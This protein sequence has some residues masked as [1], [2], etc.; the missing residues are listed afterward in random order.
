MSSE[1][2]NTGYQTDAQR[3]TS[4]SLP[5]L[6]GDGLVKLSEAADAGIQSVSG[7][8][9]FALPEAYDTKSLTDEGSLQDSDEESFV[10]LDPAAHLYDDIQV[11]ETILGWRAGSAEFH[12]MR[13]RI[14]YFNS[15]TQLLAVSRSNCS[16][17]LGCGIPAANVI[18]HFLPYPYNRLPCSGLQNFD[19]EGL[20]GKSI[21]IRALLLF[22]IFL[23]D[24]AM[25]KWSWCI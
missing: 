1:V 20:V 13:S 10:L 17:E 25:H 24:V 11:R 5:E 4:Q 21:G 2:N 15:R 9:E 12:A 22:R 6:I 7:Y 19:C 23:G 14:I 18:D 3:T 8:V 16:S